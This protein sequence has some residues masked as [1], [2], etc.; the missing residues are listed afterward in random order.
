MMEYIKILAEGLVNTTLITVLSCIL[1]LLLG[2][3]LTI[4]AGKV[5]VFDHI[6]SWLSLP[7]EC[8]CPIPLMMALYHLPS[9]VDIDIFHKIFRSLGILHLYSP[10]LVVF[11]LSLCYLLYMPSR[12]VASYSIFK[13]ILYNGLGLLSNLL[14]WSTIASFLAVPD[15]YRAANT[16]FMRS[17]EAWVLLIPLLAIGLALLVLELARRLVKSLMK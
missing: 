17:F 11:T 7:L 6:G 3:L 2:I 8:L 12:Y 4:L 9:L 16:I 13:N 14:K 1:P 5:K 10:C 15:L